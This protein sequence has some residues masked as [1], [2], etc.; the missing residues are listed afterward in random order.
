MRS[1]EGAG[2]GALERPGGGMGEN[3][4]V[5]QGGACPLRTKARSSS[6]QRIG[7]ERPF[8]GG[9]CGITLFDGKKGLHGI[10]SD[11]SQSQSRPVTPIS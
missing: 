10:K 8:G 11:K 9:G 1:S 3:W 4:T 5:C 6:P 7:T 2:E